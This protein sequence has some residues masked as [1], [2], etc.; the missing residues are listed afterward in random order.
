MERAMHVPGVLDLGGGGGG[1]GQE[2]AC[3]VSRGRQYRELI[4]HV[5][6]IRVTCAFSLFRTLPFPFACSRKGAFA[7]Q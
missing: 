2:G 3:D 1:G 4:V 5:E 6:C 7:P